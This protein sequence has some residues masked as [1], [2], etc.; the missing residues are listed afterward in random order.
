MWVY[1]SFAAILI[2][3]VVIFWII[4]KKFPALAILDLEHLPGRKEAKFKEQMLRQRFDRDLAKWGQFFNRWRRILIRFHSFLKEADEMLAKTR[5]NF[6]LERKL[7]LKT[8][9]E[10]VAAWFSEAKELIKKDELDAAEE[11]LIAII[12]INPRFLPAFIELG[13]VYFKARKYVEAKQ[14]FEHALKTLARRQTPEQADY[15]PKKELYF[16]LAQANRNLDN[17][18]AA[19]DNL[20][21]ALELEPNNPRYLDLILDLSIIKKDYAL[22]QSLLNRFSIAN[23]EN[24]KLAELRERVEQIREGE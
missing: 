11:K 16:S 23:P 12:G 22:A 18:A 6:R 13:D 14:S 1:I 10:K 2:C 9:Q 15:W 17:L 5:A 3:L 4:S 20:H 21:E 8:R 7:D 19:I 24:Q